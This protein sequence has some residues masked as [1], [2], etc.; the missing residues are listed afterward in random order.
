[1]FLASRLRR[2]PDQ[3]PAP[4]P[5]LIRLV[6]IATIIAQG[7][8]AVTGSIVRVTGSGLG[9]PEWPQCFEGSLTPVAHD[10][11]AALNQWV[12][13]GNRM[14]TGV[15]GVVAF[16][17]LVLALLVRP[18]RR[19]LIL[20]ALTMPVGVAVQ[21]GVGGITVLTGLAWW[22]VGV[23]FLL[24]MVLVWLAVL[25]LAAFFEGDEPPRWH[26]PRPLPRLLVAATAV[27]AMVLAA[28]V[29]VTAAGPHSGDAATPRLA[30]D[31][32][33]LARVHAGL[34]VGYLA[35]LVAVGIAVRTSGAP[36]RLWRRFLVL[37]AVVL[38]QGTIGEV[39]YFT[40]VPEALVST[41]VLGA[42]CVVGAMATLWAAARERT[43][44]G[45][46]PDR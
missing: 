4:A 45:D 22:T 46:T 21:A 5:W 1:M 20:L 39:Q 41:H 25:L 30:V 26:G 19:R 18:H 14:L 7:G 42:A 2:L 23:H 16:G 12:E 15:V 32:P 35:L 3:L 13:F 11:V 9:C 38:A 27:L 43:G 31:I 33:L 37:G 34:L 24:S 6:A 29:L 40:G 28:G 17:C 8:I 10:D 36:A 44:P